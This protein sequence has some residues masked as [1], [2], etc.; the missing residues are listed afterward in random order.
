V[1]RWLDTRRT[2]APHY[3]V[4][5][6]SLVLA[7][8]ALSCGGLTW[9]G[10]SGG[11]GGSRGS[12]CAAAGGQCLPLGGRAVCIEAP[13]SAQDC[14]TSLPSSCCLEWSSVDGSTAR[15]TDAAGD[16]QRSSSDTGSPD[17]PSSTSDASDGSSAGD[18]SAE[19]D[20]RTEGDGGA[21]SGVGADCTTMPCG[22]PLVCCPAVNKCTAATPTDCWGPVWIACTRASDCPSG[23]VCCVGPPVI[24]SGSFS[25]TC[26]TACILTST[27]PNDSLDQGYAC[28]VRDGN[29]GV[30]DCPG[31]S[32]ASS[33]QQVPGAPSSL[34]LCVSQPH[35]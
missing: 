18:G 6:L 25:S 4:R 29:G 22:P 26:R 1:A 15:S 33:C 13:D 20:S 10:G 3:W 32:Q 28:N 5:K 14:E 27:N 8:L 9:G 2:P 24:E 11:G 35:P 16:D 17:A 30:I 21:E 23:D 7:A 12:N 34:G 31:A 19:G